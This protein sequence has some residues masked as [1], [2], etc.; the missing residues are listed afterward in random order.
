MIYESA[1]NIEP[2]NFTGIFLYG[3][4]SEKCVKK[5]MTMTRLDVSIPNDSNNKGR[6]CI[7]IG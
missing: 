5:I 1:M 2:K 7:S 4:L 6:D 3:A